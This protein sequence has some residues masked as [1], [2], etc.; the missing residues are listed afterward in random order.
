MAGTLR[1][2]HAEPGRPD[3]WP[4]PGD[5]LSRFGAEGGPFDEALENAWHCPPQLLRADGEA[6]SFTPEGFL[7]SNALLVK[8][9]GRNQRGLH[10]ASRFLA[11]RKG[12]ALRQVGWRQV[13]FSLKPF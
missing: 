2:R 3:P 5:C 1:V 13:K 6:I 9:L 4:A 11:F 7:V 12:G 8:L 10:Q